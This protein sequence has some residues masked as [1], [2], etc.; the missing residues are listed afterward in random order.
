[1][2]RCAKTQR[3]YPF[4]QSELERVVLGTAG[5]LYPFGLQIK[6]EILMLTDS[7]RVL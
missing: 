7:L 2:G 6:V 1:M 5:I 4:S 3:A